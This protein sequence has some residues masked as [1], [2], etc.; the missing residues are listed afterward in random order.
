MV[1]LYW[2]FLCGSFILFSCYLEKRLPSGN[3]CLGSPF[4]K[5]WETYNWVFNLNDFLWVLAIVFYFEYFL[6]SLFPSNWGMLKCYRT[7]FTIP[8][9]GLSY[10]LLLKWKLVRRHGK[11]D[12][13]CSY[14]QIFLWV[15]FSWKRAENLIV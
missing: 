9:L 14:F 4:D 8:A 12:S 10:A 13:L 5:Q 3:L 11:I 1:S 7:Q 15:H 6:L 2:C